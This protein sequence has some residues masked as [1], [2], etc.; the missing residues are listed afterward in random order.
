MRGTHD[1]LVLINVTGRFIPAHAGNTANYRQNDRLRAVHPRACGEH[2]GQ[3]P[4]DVLEVGSSP[5]MRGTLGKA[6]A[7]LIPLRFIP[8]HAGNTPGRSRRCAARPV[9]PRACG[10]HSFSSAITSASSGSSP[11]MRGTLQRYRPR[12]S[13]GRFIPAHAGNTTP[14]A[15]CTAAASVHPRACGEHLY[16]HTHALQ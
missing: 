10:E 4:S 6:G 11:R 12:F 7:D 9:H 5:R 2:I 13:L 3:Q 15:C 8:A 14:G 16:G 1:G